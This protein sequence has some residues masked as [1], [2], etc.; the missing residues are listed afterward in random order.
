VGNVGDGII[1]A[2]DPTTGAFL[3]QL[4]DAN[5]KVIRISGLWA[6]TFGNGA[7]GGKPDVLYFTAGPNGFTHGR[8]G[9]I[10]AQ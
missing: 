1:N 4:A 7:L 6:L 3:G 5:G 2:F 9:S 8:F 10:T